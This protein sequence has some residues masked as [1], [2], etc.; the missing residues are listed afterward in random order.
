MYNAYM[1]AYDIYVHKRIH[2]VYENRLEE[3]I[4]C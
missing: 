3:V 4:L 1:Y 2:Y